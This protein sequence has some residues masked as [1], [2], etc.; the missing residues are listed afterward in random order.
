MENLSI[1]GADVKVYKHELV[2][3]V[4]PSGTSK[5]Q[6][7]LP[8]LPNLRNVHLIGIELLP[9]AVMTQTP[10]GVPSNE[11]TGIVNSFLNLEGYNGKIFFKDYPL[12]GLMFTA[13]AGTSTPV[14][15]FK[16]VFSGQKCN[17][18]KCYITYL[19]GAPAATFAFTLM[20]YYRDAK[21]IEKQDEAASFR[22]RS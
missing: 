16:K 4:I 9:H 19:G 15:Q 13:Y 6:F 18:P 17:W 21:A 11:P 8:D 20:V 2:Q 1:T 14:E 10:D 7:Y 3:V 5:T 12:G 22:N